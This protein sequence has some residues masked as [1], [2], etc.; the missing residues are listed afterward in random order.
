[1]ARG[2][3]E[4]GMSPHAVYIGEDHHA[5]ALRLAQSVKKGDWVLVKGSRIVKMEEIIKELR[6]AL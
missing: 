5:I 4:A 6:D 1:V 2:A 3:E